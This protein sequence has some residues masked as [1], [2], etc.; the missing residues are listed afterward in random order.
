M[1][2][3]DVVA[4]TIEID[5]TLP[6]LVESAVDAAEV[7]AAETV[8]E[9]LPVIVPGLAQP[10]SPALPENTADN[11]SVE[12]EVTADSATDSEPPVVATPVSAI[13]IP[14]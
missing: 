13:A 7:P 12:T 11:D 2:P 5:E 4:E 14:E 1:A 6:F 8:T 9:S 10:E 3:A